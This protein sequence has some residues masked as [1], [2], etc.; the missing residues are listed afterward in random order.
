LLRQQFTIQK[1]FIGTFVAALLLAFVARE[2]LGV[3]LAAFFC[4]GS[5]IGISVLCFFTISHLVDVISDSI[6][7]KQIGGLTARYRWA[8]L[9]GL[10]ALWLF[11]TIVISNF[12]LENSIANARYLIG[13]GWS[14]CLIGFLLMVSQI[15][16]KR[17]IRNTDGV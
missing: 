5:W 11:F 16:R 2:P 12:V 4:V 10:I 14:I 3:A 1:L 17:R 9:D 15:F 6:R 8:Y 7:R 13:C